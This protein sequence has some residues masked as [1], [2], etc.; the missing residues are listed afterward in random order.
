VRMPT[1]RGMVLQQHFNIGH[2]DECDVRYHV[3]M[4]SPTGHVV[5]QLTPSAPPGGEPAQVTD[6][7]NIPNERQ[8]RG[9]TKTWENISY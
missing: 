6:K 3:P 9:R 1:N 7:P 4:D 5:T 8:L 2:I